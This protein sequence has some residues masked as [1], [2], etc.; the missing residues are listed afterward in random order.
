MRKYHLTDGYQFRGYTPLQAIDGVA[1]DGQ[2]RL[3]R[4]KRVEK[5]QIAQ[6]AGS[7]IGRSTIGNRSECGICRAAICWFTLG[8]SIAESCVRPTAW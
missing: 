6:P 4:L 3:I 8:S 2:A 5:K 1:D 7:R